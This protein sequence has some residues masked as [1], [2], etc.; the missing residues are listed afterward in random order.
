MLHLNPLQLVG[1]IRSRPIRGT[2]FNLVYTFQESKK[3][4]KFGYVKSVCF[5]NNYVKKISLK[6][7]SK[8]SDN[9]SMSKVD[10]KVVNVNLMLG[11]LGTS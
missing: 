1:G 7:P 2:H 8:S 11:Q 3:L 4:V 10:V 9:K 6:K 5:C